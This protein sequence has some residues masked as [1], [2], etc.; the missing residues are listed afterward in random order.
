MKRIISLFMCIAV[1]SLWGYAQSDTRP[2]VGVAQ[3]G[4]EGPAE[5]GAGFE[6]PLEEVQELA[7]V[8]PQHLQQA[9]HLLGDADAEA[10]GDDNALPSREEEGEA[11]RQAGGLPQALEEGLEIGVVPDSAVPLEIAVL[12]FGPPVSADNLTGIRNILDLCVVR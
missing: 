5:A 12:L 8:H 9:A 3:Q 7:L 10:G 11:L 4:E 6:L 1:H 2:V